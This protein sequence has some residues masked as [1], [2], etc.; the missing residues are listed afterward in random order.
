MPTTQ[1]RYT[2]TDTGDIRAM[3]DLAQRRWP[4]VSDRRQ[5]LLRL[6][7]TGGEQLK[8]ELDAGDRRTRMERQAAAL[9]RATDLVD[10]DVLLSDAPW[11]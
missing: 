6:A 2:V 9:G 4:Q 8:A 7:R 11:R 10:P 3:L 5:L 1:P